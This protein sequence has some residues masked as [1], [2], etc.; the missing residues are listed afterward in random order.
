MKKSFFIGLCALMAAMM[1]SCGPK[2]PTPN[3][4]NPEPLDINMQELPT[5]C[6]SLLKQ[7]TAV[8]FAQLRQAGFTYSEYNRY[9]NSYDFR[10]D[11]YLTFSISCDKN[12]INAVMISYEL[13]GEEALETID[14]L[15]WEELA[16]DYAI[17]EA[18]A[19]MAIYADAVKDE[20]DD[21]ETYDREEFNGFIHANATKDELIFSE[22]GQGVKGAFRFEGGFMRSEDGIIGD[23][24]YIVTTE[25]PFSDED[26]DELW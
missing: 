13:I 6:Q 2:E 9:S 19:G 17:W 16:Y 3:N 8:V 15:H 23:I 26:F 5:L 1:S 7:D 24:G 22:L 21:L 11:D 14:W 4:E 12:I 25:Q 18:W 20:Y 10:K